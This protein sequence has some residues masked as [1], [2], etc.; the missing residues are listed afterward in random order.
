MPDFAA[1]FVLVLMVIHH[2]LAVSIVHTYRLVYVKPYCHGKQHGYPVCALSSMNS[3]QAVLPL[4][5]LSCQ[6]I[7]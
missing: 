1:E 4:Q 7:H 6:S 3:L 2:M 5:H